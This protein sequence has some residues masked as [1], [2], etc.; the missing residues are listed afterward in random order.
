VAKNSWYQSLNFLGSREK[1]EVKALQ[2]RLDALVGEI[3]DTDSYDVKFYDAEPSSFSG[4]GMFQIAGVDEVMNA[5]QLQRVYCTETWVY[6]AVTAIAKTIA[7]LPLKLEKKTTVK[8]ATINSVTGEQESID[9]DHWVDASG[10]KLF[11][12]FQYPNKYTT[13]T[14]LMMLLVIDLL[15]AGEY[16]VYLD[17]DVDLTTIT[18]S[19]DIESDDPATPFGRLR[20][21]MA[22]AQTPIK[23]MYRIPPNLM[24]PVPTEDG[25]GIAGYMM[26]SAA[27]M[28]AFNIA[29]MI[30]VKLPNPTNPAQGLSPLIPAFKPVLLDRYSSEHMIR[31]YKS[32]A[33]LGGI[34]QTEK[35]LNKE[36]LSR[37]QRSFENNFTG[38]QNHHRT[39]ILPP[40]MNYKAVEQNPAETAL[41][42]FCKYNREAVLSTYNVPPIKVG[43]M[44]HA[45]YANAMVQLKIFFS[46]TVIPLLSFI[47]DG[48]NL[49]NT[50]LPD[51]RTF[52]FRFDIAQVEALKENF[53][54]KAEAAKFMIDSGLS[55]NEVRARVWEAGPVADGD[56]IKVIE[57]IKSG[58]GD[59]GGPLFLGAPQDGTSHKGDAPESSVQG[60]LAG[61]P[62]PAVTSIMNILGR[63]GR[64]RI[65]KDAALEMLHTI[66]GMPKSVAA[67]LL[68]MEPPAQPEPPTPSPKADK[69][70]DAE[71]TE[72]TQPDAQ[73]IES[74][75]I[76]PTKGSYSDRV[77]ELTQLY[78]D[79]DKLS[80]ANA[81]ARAIEQAKLEGFTDDGAGEGKD[82]EAVA[83]PELRPAM[84]AGE[85]LKPCECAGKEGCECDDEGK[86]S[87][88]SLEEFISEALGKLN[89]DEEITPD[90]IAQLMEVYKEQNGEA[91]TNKES[92][93]GETR[94]YAFGWT[95]DQHV[96]HWKGFI[97]KT[98]PLIE[99][100]HGEIKEFFS[101][102]KSIIMKRIGANIKAYGL[103]KAR[104]E[105]D[106]EE[107]LKNVG[108]LEALIKWYEDQGAEKLMQAFQDGHADTLATFVFEAP[109]KEAEEALR[110]YLADKVK[111]IVG[112][113]QDQLRE[114]LA[115]AF[116]AEKPMAEVSKAITE[117]FSEMEEGRA[118]TIARTE[119]LT[120]VSLGREAKRQ[121]WQEEFPEKKLRKMWVSA[122]D[123]RVRDSHNEL[124]GVAVDSD[125]EFKDGL[126]FPRDPNGDAEEVINCRCTDIT[127]SP[128]DEDTVKDTLPPD[129]SDDDSSDEEKTLDGSSDKGGPGSGRHPTGRKPRESKPRESKPKPAGSSP[130]VISRETPVGDNELVNVLKD[131]QKQFDKIAKENPDLARSVRAWSSTSYGVIRKVQQGKEIDGPP[132]LKEDAAAKAK[133]LEEN[134][135]KLPEYKGPL[136]RELSKVDPSTFKEG[137][138]F[139]TDA[140]SSFTAKKEWGGVKST[141]RLVVDS[142]KSGRAIWG[143]SNIADEME[144][145]VPKGTKYSIGKVE[146]GDPTVV[147]LSE[148]GEGKALKA[149]DISAAVNAALD[150]MP[151]SRDRNNDDGS[152]AYSPDEERDG[153]GR[154]TSGGSGADEHSA[155]T[156]HADGRPRGMSK[157]TYDKTKRRG[158]NEGRHVTL[159]HDELTEVLDK[160]TYSLISAGRNMKDEGD[161]KL[162]D[163]QINARYAK[164]EADL[165]KSGYSYTRVAD[166]TAARK[167]AFSFRFTKPIA[168]R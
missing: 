132:T 57:D 23:A 143:M 152:K 106:I 154:W 7:G 40:G 151:G 60:A 131:T 27:G 87:Q 22:A 83:H 63:V 162:T 1:P 116:A 56:K 81:V 58:K 4:G 128:D 33:R 142:N 11:D 120:A 155:P 55:V 138:T 129:E 65:S 80:L 67:R 18:T 112:T 43:I 161:A 46:D 76:T 52:R 163:E 150:A 71:K 85:A 54:D 117:K 68:G 160:G 31:F 119:T 96:A 98:A 126:R 135:G 78:M 130:K 70:P 102:F 89:A 105:D 13:K 113:T 158:P 94:V 14:E 127:F 108:D 149:E 77:A 6:V 133:S 48:F 159:N 9:Q 36:Q 49:K 66:Y 145:L 134:F 37:F 84:I 24:K 140:F 75:S 41:L 3:Q 107:I 147:H 26:Q 118:Q 64:G 146:K 51:S 90:F 101:R 86:K 61:L 30:H 165:K 168:V 166:T 19:E 99:K 28:Y 156:T 121:Q 74:S 10:E 139:Q 122:Q 53:K 12:R 91:V 50:L 167:T 25:L 82:G 92:Q 47:Q 124:D 17:S 15:T 35:T 79:R 45:N 20:Q 103:R 39:L 88:Q 72:P 141:V 29:E 144:V 153:H 111:G 62:G 157:E 104:D 123:D 95:K 2:N 148:A 109:S 114:V 34:I 73:S 125:E 136:A 21:V 115:D 42:E 137:G 69:K 164:L 97:D 32:G 44:D 16:F 8:K 100:R 38:R 59:G 110:K 5:E 93:I